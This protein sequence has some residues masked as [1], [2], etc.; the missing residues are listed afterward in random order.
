M[1]DFAG[2]AALGE[3]LRFLGALDP[4]AVRAHV[5][6]LVARALAGLAR[7]SQVRVLG[8]EKTL[9]DGSLVSFSGAHPGFS[10]KDFNLYLNH[11]LPGL[12]VAVRAGE[13]CA[14][15]LHR[16]RGI[17]GTIRISFFA[18]N[19]GA[20]VDLFLDALESYVREACR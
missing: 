7:V 18:Y 16:R 15:L 13:H 2:A 9:L 12:C 19:T 1:P 6:G 14:H 20:E 11:E 10:L 5:S 17:E 4:A 3:A 8:D